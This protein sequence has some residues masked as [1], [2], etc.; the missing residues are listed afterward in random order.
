MTCLHNVVCTLDL[1]DSGRR[2][3]SACGKDNIVALE[4]QH[5]KRR[6]TQPPLTR[7]PVEPRASAMALPMPR[8]DP[9][10]TH[11]GDSTAPQSR[12]AQFR[13]ELHEVTLRGG[14][15]VY[16]LPAGA[17]TGF[18][19][20]TA[21]AFAWGVRGLRPATGLQPQ[22]WRLVPLA[23]LNT[24]VE[25]LVLKKPTQS[26]VRDQQLRARTTARPRAPPSQCSSRDR[27]NS[28]TLLSQALCGLRTASHSCLFTQAA[29][30]EAHLS[31]PAS[32]R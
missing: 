28:H 21:A 9:V 16:N 14:V 29:A 25:G 19:T 24:L 18:S 2:L 13:P 8:E 26:T 6:A 1:G 17:V 10:T 11:T 4:R 7:A 15:Q 27:C 3:N 5:S 22:L 31:E 30:D 12:H 23:A 32:G 20:S